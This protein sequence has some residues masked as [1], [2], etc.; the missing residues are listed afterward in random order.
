MTAW[1]KWNLFS[2]SPFSWWLIFLL[3][4]V[5]YCHNSIEFNIYSKLYLQNYFIKCT[6]TLAG[7]IFV[8]SADSPSSTDST[9]VHPLK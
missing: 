1:Y 2:L 3:M 6:D 7:G 5:N 4:R 8:Q 9:T